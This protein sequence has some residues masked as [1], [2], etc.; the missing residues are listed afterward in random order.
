[1][2]SCRKWL[3]TRGGHKGMFGCIQKT[4]G[5]LYHYFQP[6]LPF[7]STSFVQDCTSCSFHL[8]ERPED[9]LMPAISRAWYNA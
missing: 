5:K 6:S 8:Q 9:D 3:L 4:V 2:V 7:F 1:M